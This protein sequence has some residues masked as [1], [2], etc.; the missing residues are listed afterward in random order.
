MSCMTVQTT[1]RHHLWYRQCDFGSS[2]SEE[3][4]LFWTGGQSSHHELLTHRPA[5]LNKCFHIC[6]KNQKDR[7]KG[8]WMSYRVLLK[9]CAE[10]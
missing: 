6:Y 2:A 4:F 7:P 5:T 9:G 10:P 3:V 1:Y 8:Y